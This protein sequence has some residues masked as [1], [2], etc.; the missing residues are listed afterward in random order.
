MA[1]PPGMCP[2]LYPT[3]LSVRMNAESPCQGGHS[4]HAK[5]HTTTSPTRTLAQATA[6]LHY[7]IPTCTQVPTL[8]ENVL[9]RKRLHSVAYYSL[10]HHRTH[11]VPNTFLLAALRTPRQSTL[12][13]LRTRRKEGDQPKQ[14]HNKGRKRRQRAARSTHPLE[15]GGSQLPRIPNRLL[16]DPA[17]SNGRE[18]RPH[19]NRR[20]RHCLR[21][22]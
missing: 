7:R 21:I 20:H 5:E 14:K 22:L 15:E 1:L 13:N 6:A 16:Q 19:R 18:R 10:A 3:A 4:T 2:S 17:Q 9:Y 11:T 12:A 8:V